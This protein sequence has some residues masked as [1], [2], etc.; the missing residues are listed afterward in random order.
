MELPPT[1]KGDFIE[2]VLDGQQRLTTLF[3]SLK[4]L[5]IKREDRED[6]YSEFQIDLEANEDDPVVLTGLADTNHNK[7]IRLYD[8]LYGRLKLF[9]KY[10]DPLQDKIQEYKDR[11]NAYQ[12][13]AVLIKEAPIDVATEIFTRFERRRKAVDCI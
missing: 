9:S 12:F 1:P 4:G 6:D 10:S 13:S 3:A 11:I 8:L 5:K 7:V 2:Y